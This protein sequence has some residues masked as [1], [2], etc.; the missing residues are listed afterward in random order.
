MAAPKKVSEVGWAY[1]RTDLLKD[2]IELV[3]VLKELDE[4][5]YIRVS[6]AVVERLHLTEYARAGVPRHLQTNNHT[7][8][9]DPH[10]IFIA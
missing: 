2:K 10:S 9:F 7:L 6:L 1:E 4:L 3:R 8:H 5:D